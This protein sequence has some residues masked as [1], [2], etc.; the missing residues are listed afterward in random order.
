MKDHVDM[1][2]QALE[3]G[4]QESDVILRLGDPVM[5]AKELS[6]E[7]DLNDAPRVE[8]KQY[9]VWKSY[10]PNKDSLT[11]FVKLVSED[12][13]VQPSKNDQIRILYKGK[14]DIEKYQISY[15]N[16]ELN[17]E[18]PK[19]RG[20]HFMRLQSDEMNFIIEVPKTLNF[21]ACNQHGVS[22]D[23]TLQNMEI[24]EFTIN[25]TSGDCE[26]KNSIFEEARWN[27]VS[28][29]LKA[30]DLSITNLVISMVS[31][32]SN[33]KQVNIKSDLSLSTVSGDATIEDS[34]AETVNISTVSGDLEAKE[35]YIESIKFKSVSGDCDIHNKE[36]TPINI[37]RS[38]S[39]SGEIRIK[40]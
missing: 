1:I 24:G 10:S 5:L 21:K 13:L 39:V 2:N 8:S 17:I 11:L 29:D 38:V 25:T 23:F 26:I 14:V 20:L 40:S 33:L 12:L 19:T 16:G 31:G 15:K 3:P 32:D 28:G 4:H 37:L 22:S 34:K 36:K 6:E 35:F 27:T 7:S 9:Q 18:A 30:S